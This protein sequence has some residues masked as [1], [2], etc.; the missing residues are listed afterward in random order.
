MLIIIIFGM[1]FVAISEIQSNAAH[2]NPFNYGTCPLSQFATGITTNTLD[3]GSASNSNYLT[4]QTSAFFDYGTCPNNQYATAITTTTLNC[5]SASNTNYLT[6]Q[7]LVGGVAALLY[8]DQ[9]SH[10]HTISAA[11][12]SIGA[13]F[14][15]S[16]NSYSYI[17]IQSYGYVSFTAATNT[18]QGELVQA[19]IAG[20]PECG[21]QSFQ[22]AIG[23]TYVFPWSIQCLYV[24][25][26]GGVVLIAQQGAAGVADAHTTVTQVGFTVWGVV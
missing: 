1:V 2:P 4:T 24:L 8:K 5:A 15:V 16:A 19:S 22:I 13:T 23:G 14:T 18:G 7:T 25:T 21:T 26:A 9:T 6:T 3:C 17:E 11:Y 12:T 10:S 20:S